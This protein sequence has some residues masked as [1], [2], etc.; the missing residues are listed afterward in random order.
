L[1][2]V[3]GASKR[4]QVGYTP[5]VRS[6]Y[7]ANVAVTFGRRRARFPG[8]GR[9]RRSYDSLLHA[10]AKKAAPA[11]L[12]RVAVLRF[13]RVSPRLSGDFRENLIANNA[14]AGTNR[15]S[16][17]AQNLAVAAYLSSP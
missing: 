13:K 2:G 5:T 11:R 10:F 16:A 9:R 14:T 7:T 4:T 6:R 15:R 3:E 8:S 1:H 12:R 17:F